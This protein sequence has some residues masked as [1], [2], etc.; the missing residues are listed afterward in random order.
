MQTHSPDMSNL[1]SFRYHPNPI[2]TGAV[3][4]SD[5]R[6]VCCGIARGFI[7]VASVY[8]KR[9]EELRS[10]LC[11]W[12]IA[13]GE[14]SRRFDASFADSVPLIQAGVPASV[15]EEVN[16]RT[17]AYVSWQQ[18]EWLSHCGDACAFHGDASREDLE[19]ISPETRDQFFKK[20]HLNERRW[21]NLQE[22][23]RPGGDPAI[24]KFVCL[25][26]DRVLLGMDFP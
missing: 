3:E 19:R 17:P 23:Y 24:Y 18:Q 10:R 14:A 5:V 25:H 11:P 15:V 9:L 20:F 21:S 2:R 22:H 16:K 26:C 4:P 6:C 1:P 12:C 7:Y 13:N 8:G